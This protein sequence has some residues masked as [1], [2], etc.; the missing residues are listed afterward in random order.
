MYSRG[1]KL[2]ASCLAV[3]AL[4]ITLPPSLSPS[5][6]R[7]KNIWLLRRSFFCVWENWSLRSLLSH[8]VPVTDQTPLVLSIARV[9]SLPVEFGGIKSL[10]I[11]PSQCLRFG[12]LGPPR[13]LQLG[14]Q[15]AKCTVTV[16]K[17]PA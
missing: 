12:Y 3:Y 15:S 1:K 9:I 17:S 14:K 2:C 7:L 6:P 11:N 13:V 16:N 8:G 5:Q 10:H 4:V